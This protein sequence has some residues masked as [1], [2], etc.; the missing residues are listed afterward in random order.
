MMI[1]PGSGGLLLA[2]EN[3]ANGGGGGGGGGGRGF[4][5]S[6]EGVCISGCFTTGEAACSSLGGTWSPGDQNCDIGGV[7]YVLGSCTI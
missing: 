1:V 2:F 3:T 7:F 5:I 6:D 4:C